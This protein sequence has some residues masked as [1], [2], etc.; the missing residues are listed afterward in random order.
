[1]KAL[2]NALIKR[3]DCRAEGKNSFRVTEQK[4]LEPEKQQA[5]SV[6]FC[7]L[8]KTFIYKHQWYH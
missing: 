6:C 1:M 8:R 7:G 5:T 3:Y 2:I 4:G